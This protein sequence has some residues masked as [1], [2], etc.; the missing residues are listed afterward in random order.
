MKEFTPQQVETLAT[1]LRDND[2]VHAKRDY[3][4]L[5]VSIDMMA[6]SSDILR[7]T[8]GMVQHDGDIVEELQ[9]Q[10]KKT[11]ELA[12]C[13]FTEETRSALRA[14]VGKFAASV[15]EDKDRLLFPFTTRRYRDIVKGW[16]QMLRLDPKRYSGHSL[17]RT[18]AKMIYAATGN[19]MAV[20]E[21]LGHTSLR[22]TQ[23]Y[24]DVERSAALDLA[25]KISP[26]KVKS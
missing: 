11:G 25:R 3:A 16:A 1:F 5:C 17:R 18:K 13:V 21:L 12:S 14:Y 19:A 20:K 24:L 22:H 26:L 2:T 7:L 9:F 10:Q 15:R 6:R 23:A 4:L 8:F